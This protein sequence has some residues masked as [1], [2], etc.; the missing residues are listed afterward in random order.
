MIIGGNLRGPAE[1]DVNAAP[2]LN[3]GRDAAR[4]QYVHLSTVI[5][6]EMRGWLEDGK[7]YSNFETFA[8]PGGISRKKSHL[9]LLLFLMI[10][11][12]FAV[13]CKCHHVMLVEVMAPRGLRSLRSPLHNTKGMETSPR[14]RPFL[15][16]LWPELPA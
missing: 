10:Q 3:Y 2:L 14:S 5:T 16:S 7:I 4:S 11:V 8:Q 15:L 13:I 1:P 12:K 6:D 9:F